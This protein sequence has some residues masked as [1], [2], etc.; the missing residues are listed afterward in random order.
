MKERFPPLEQKKKEKEKTKR[1]LKLFPLKRKK[2]SP[3]FWKVNAFPEK[4]RKK[5]N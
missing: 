2:N 5:K 3:K 1:T 4:K